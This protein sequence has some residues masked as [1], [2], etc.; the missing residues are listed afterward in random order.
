MPCGRPV[1]QLFSL[2]W[3]RETARLR[4]RSGIDGHDGSGDV[5]RLASEEIVD[6]V[7]HVADVGKAAQRAAAHDLFTAL[8]VEAA[9]HVRVHESGC[10]GVHVDALAADS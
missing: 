3:V 10:D 1:S 6:G 8:A 7:R 5:L 9:G 2:T 4:R